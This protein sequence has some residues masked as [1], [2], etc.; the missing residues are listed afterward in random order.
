MKEAKEKAEL[1]LSESHK[2]RDERL[3]KLRQLEHRHQSDAAAIEALR[4]KVVR[5]EA[6]ISAKNIAA[7]REAE[8]QEVRERSKWICVVCTFRV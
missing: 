1:Q 7:G 4:E 6:E 8:L 2:V 5:A 3:K